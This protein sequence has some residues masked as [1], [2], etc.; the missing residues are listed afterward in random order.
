MTVILCAWNVSETSGVLS[1]F[2]LEHV[3]EK[4]FK[5]SP[6]DFSCPKIS[7]G[8]ITEF[9]KSDNE[10]SNLEMPLPHVLHAL[11]NQLCETR[12]GF[13]YSILRSGDFHYAKCTFCQA[14]HPN[15]LSTVP[16]DALC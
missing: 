6:L 9:L 15:I 11:G 2:S 13:A 12:R 14:S 16:G 8:I 1:L 3:G 5:T 7:Q 4:L 10:R